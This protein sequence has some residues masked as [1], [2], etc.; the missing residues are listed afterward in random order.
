MFLNMKVKPPVGGD[1]YY[2]LN[3]WVMESF[4]LFKRTIH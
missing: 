4:D 2:I 1:K 3:V